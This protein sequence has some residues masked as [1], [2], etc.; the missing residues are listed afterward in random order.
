M[1]IQMRKKTMVRKIILLVTDHE[2]SEETSVVQSFVFW[3]KE[4]YIRQ[5][6][7]SILVQKIRIT[8]DAVDVI[9]YLWIRLTENV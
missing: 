4:I 7:D 2:T 5:Q 3:P 9:S 1:R 6:R 8:I